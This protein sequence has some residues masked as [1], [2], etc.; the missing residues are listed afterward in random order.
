L[1]TDRQ[2]QAACSKEQ[3]LWL[4]IQT[5]RSNLGGQLGDALDKFVREV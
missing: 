3:A 1:E 5:L 2:G 4:E